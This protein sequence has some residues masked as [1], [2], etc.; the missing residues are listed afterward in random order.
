MIYIGLYSKTFYDCNDCL[1]SVF[2]NLNLVQYLRLRL[3][4]CLGVGY[5]QILDYGRSDKR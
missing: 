2:V 1:V 4:A 3:G 5:K